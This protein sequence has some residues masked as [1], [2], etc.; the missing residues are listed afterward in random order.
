MENCKLQTYDDSYKKCFVTL[1]EYIDV[2]SFEVQDFS[3]L[4]FILNKECE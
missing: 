2:K 3:D 1:N 4:F